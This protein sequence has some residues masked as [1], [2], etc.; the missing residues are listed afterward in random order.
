MTGYLLDTNVISETFRPSPDRTVATFLTGSADLWISTPCIHELFY[1]LELMPAGR[2]R[3][4]VGTWIAGLKLQFKDR[5]LTLDWEGAQAAGAYRARGRQEGLN[6]HEIDSQV[7]GIALRHGLIVATR[8][9]KDF[10]PMGV[11][12]INPW[13]GER[14]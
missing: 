14:G 10:A 7:A 6:G 9:L 11:P 13:T 8:N 2:N 5:I 1:G 3:Q 12:L 4:A